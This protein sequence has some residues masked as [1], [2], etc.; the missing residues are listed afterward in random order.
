MQRLIT[1]DLPK[2]VGEQ[3]LSMCFYQTRCKNKM[4]VV[5]VSGNQIYVEFCSYHIN[6][7]TICIIQRSD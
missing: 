4:L 5:Y 6:I 7:C 1:Q 2:H 3:G